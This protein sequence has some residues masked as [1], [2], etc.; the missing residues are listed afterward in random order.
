VVPPGDPDL[1]NA[2]GLT[3]GPTTPW[4]VADNGTG[5]ST[6][7]NGAGVKQGLIVSVPGGPT[8]TVFNGTTGFNLPTGGKALFLFDGEDGIVR[9]WNGAQGTTAIVAGDGDQSAAG[10]IYKGLA[11]ATPPG[12]TPQL[13]A[14]DFR[15]GTVDI[16][17]STWQ[18]VSSA[19]FVDPSLPAGYA[20][21][22]IQTAGQRIFVSFAQQDADKED[23]VPGAGKGYVSVFDTS[24]NFLARVASAGPLSAPW[25]LAVAPQNFGAFSGDVLVGNFGDGRINAFKETSPGTFAPDG[26]LQSTNGNP[27]VIIGLWALEFGSGAANNGP[28]TTLYYTA[29]PFA[30]T[31]GVFGR[32]TNVGAAQGTVIAN[33]PAQLS[34]TLGNPASFGAFT[35]GMGKDYTAS[36]TATVTSTAGDGALSVTDPSTNAPGHLVNGAFS[37]PQAV[38]AQA[39]STGGTGNAAFAAVSATPATLLTYTGPVSNDAVTLT[40]KQTIGAGDALRTGTYSKTLTFTLSTTNP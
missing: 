15:N 25:G 21:Y 20:P 12:G 29:G 36:T 6:L 5:K 9:A 24:G 4:W 18:L 11:I 28:V 39:T 35:A 22:G 31:Q 30:E 8:G 40:F 13:Y 14:T 37:L 23:E 16:Y 17:S 19:K 34:L 10:A 7:Y 2:W 26:T 32:I 3:S 33:V 27:L 1:K 38:Q